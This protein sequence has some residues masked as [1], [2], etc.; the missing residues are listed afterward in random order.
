MSDTKKESSFLKLMDGIADTVKFLVVTL[1]FY[2]IFGFAFA[3][4]YQDYCKA[5]GRKFI[6]DTQDRWANMGFLSFIL[7]LVLQFIVVANIPDND[8][9]Q[10]D[11][12]NG[13]F[14]L[15]MCLVVDLILILVCFIRAMIFLFRDCK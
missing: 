5:T 10:G 14:V 7:L 11:L 1:I 6:P 13:G 9:V 8:Y 2:L 4:F 12:S 3:G 15:G